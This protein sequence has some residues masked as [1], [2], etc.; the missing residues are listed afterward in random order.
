MK[1]ADD[2]A[3]N[4][5]EEFLKFLNP[6]L[7]AYCIVRIFLYYPNQYCIRNPKCQLIKTGVKQSND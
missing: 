7:S 5:T 4:R 6:C 2:W 3:S 1:S